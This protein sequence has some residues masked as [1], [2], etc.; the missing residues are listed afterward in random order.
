MAHRQKIFLTSLGFIVVVLGLDL[1][2]ANVG[3]DWD[4]LISFVEDRDL[5]ETI[6]SGPLCTTDLFKNKS[7][8][9]FLLITAFI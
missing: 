5:G 9:Y 7:V 6:E 3:L 1:Q 4:Y 8:A 2:E